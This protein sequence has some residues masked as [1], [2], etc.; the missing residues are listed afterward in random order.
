MSHEH[1]W[2]EIVSWVWFAR[3]FFL[4]WLQLW[5][6]TPSDTDF[7][8]R[9]VSGLFESQTLRTVNQKCS[10][11]KIAKSFKALVY[12]EGKWEKGTTELGLK[13][14]QNYHY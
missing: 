14:P 5:K 2:V 13:Q 3:N 4:L 9:F 6:K 10:K 8:G 11:M 12:Q 7:P 1:G